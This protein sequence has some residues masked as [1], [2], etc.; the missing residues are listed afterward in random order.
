MQTLPGHV[1]QPR[2]IVRLAELTHVDFSSASQCC[3]VV[4]LPPLRV[5]LLMNHAADAQ[6]R[7]RRRN[8]FASVQ[9]MPLAR[10][11]PAMQVMPHIASMG[12][13][14]VKASVMK[15]LLISKYPTANDF[16]SE[17]IPGAVAE[18]KKVQAYLFEGYWEDIGTIGAFFRSQ[19]ALLEDRPQFSFYDTHAPVFSMSRF[20]PPS[21]VNVRP[22]P[23][24]AARRIAWQLH[25]KWQDASGPCCSAGVC[26]ATRRTARPCC[27]DMA[28]PV[29]TI[30][31][32]SKKIYDEI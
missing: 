22:T 10:R 16:G 28:C 2:G 7:L 25:R 12:I 17:I 4:Q 1:V 31:T 24:T 19:L 26:S 23:R 32:A 21:R 20:L 9:S 6:P 5:L 30:A 15:E 14:V 13:Y 27:K 18:G 8:A 11:R 3:L 29:C